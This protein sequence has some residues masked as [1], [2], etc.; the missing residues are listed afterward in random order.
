MLNKQFYHPHYLA[1]ADQLFFSVLILVKSRQQMIKF[2]KLSSVVFSS[3]KIRLHSTMENMCSRIFH[4]C[5]Y[6]NR[7]PLYSVQKCTI[8]CVEK[9]IGGGCGWWWW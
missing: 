8:L 5:V 6:F 1:S 7:I 3:I 4:Q 2:E 9:Y